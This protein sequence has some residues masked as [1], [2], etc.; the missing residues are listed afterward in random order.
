MQCF[1][2]QIQL[3]GDLGFVETDYDHHQGAPLQLMER[4]LLDPHV[5]LSHS[6]SHTLDM[7]RPSL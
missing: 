6:V 1:A 3:H 4:G 2:W 5:A 7:R